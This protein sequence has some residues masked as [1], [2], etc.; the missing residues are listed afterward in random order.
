M[1]DTLFTR[2]QLMRATRAVGKLRNEGT[3]SFRW[4]CLLVSALLI[5]ASGAWAQR[6]VP[7]TKDNVGVPQDSAQA[8]PHAQK[9]NAQKL[10][11]DSIEKLDMTGVKTALGNG[12]DPQLTSGTKNKY[13]VVGFLALTSDG[14]QDMRVENPEQKAVEILQVLLKA[15]AKLEPQEDVLYSPVS[16]GWALFTEALLKNGASAAR[17]M[18]GL[19]PMELA[20]RNGRTNIVELLK[21]HGVPALEPKEAAQQRLIGAAANNDI[22]GMED[23]L[24]QGADVNG[25]NRQG[26]TAL[27][28]ACQYFFGRPWQSAPILYLLKKGADPTVQG[29]DDSKYPNME[30]TALH[31]VMVMSALA[32]DRKNQEKNE[33]LKDNAASARAVITAL[34]QHGALV[35]ARDYDGQTPLHIAAKRNNIVGAQMLIDAGCKISPTDRAGKTPLDYAESAEMIKLLKAH[36]AKEQ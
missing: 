29:S 22:P 18:D 15:G 7:T 10:L 16:N 3:M 32:F 31:S 36:G 28:A 14:W 30:T 33:R 9:S 27:I 12:A 24:D 13:S 2:S 6:S 19:T 1:I 11:T 35:S 25:K 21:K 34:L 17:E 26:E 4:R 23:A 5:T 8:A 20:V